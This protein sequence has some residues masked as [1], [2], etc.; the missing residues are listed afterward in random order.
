MSDY[1]K[2]S[3]LE[4]SLMMGSY[5]NPKDH[6]TDYRAHGFRRSCWS[7]SAVVFRATTESNLF[8]N[9]EET[10][11]IVPFQPTLDDLEARDWVFVPDVYVDREIYPFVLPAGVE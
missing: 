2:L 4:A 6:G 5:Y 9:N 7:G 8:F 3:I 1:T 10:Q 11:S